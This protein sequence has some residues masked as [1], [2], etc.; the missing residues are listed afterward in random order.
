MHAT[1][2]TFLIFSSTSVRLLFQLPGSQVQAHIT[3]ET[4][5]RQL[6]KANNYLLEESN[7]VIAILH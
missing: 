3:R 4:S 1:R 2:A 7:F 5:Y 6:Q